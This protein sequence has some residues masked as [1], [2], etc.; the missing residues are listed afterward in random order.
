[1]EKKKKIEQDCFFAR[2][3]WQVKPT[4]VPIVPSTKNLITV[5]ERKSGFIG[6]VGIINHD[7]I[8][9]CEKKKKKKK[10]NANAPLRLF[11]GRYQPAF[12]IFLGIGRPLFHN[13]NRWNET[14]REQR[15]FPQIRNFPSTSLH[16]RE[17]PPLRKQARRC[18][19]AREGEK[20]DK[21]EQHHPVAPTVWWEAITLQ[22]ISFIVQ[23]RKERKSMLRTPDGRLSAKVARALS[24][25][26]WTYTAL[27]A[28]PPILPD[29]SHLRSQ[30][31]S[32]T[33]T[34][35]PWHWYLYL[36]EVR[37]RT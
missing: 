14:W 28:I 5:G 7:N 19:R 9:H 24:G 30:R 2:W 12:F 36:A 37:Q 21:P 6:N 27:L 32:P 26:G 18:Q 17:I 16:R 23:K 1:M 34:F 31:R 10:K 20:N 4:N 33:I 13:R 11:P 3:S 8:P 35:P 15:Q 29:L 25:F 22:T